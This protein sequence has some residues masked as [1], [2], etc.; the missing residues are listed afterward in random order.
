MTNEQLYDAFTARWGTTMVTKPPT[1]HGLGFCGDCG[2]TF[3]RTRSDQLTCVACE[4]GEPGD[5]S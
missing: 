2:I 1:A 5:A 4:A 3:Q